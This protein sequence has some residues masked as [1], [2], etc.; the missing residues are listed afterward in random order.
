[1]SFYEDDD[2]DLIEPSYPGAEPP[3]DE[4]IDQSLKLLTSDPQTRLRF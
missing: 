1:M 3:R 4:F 2:S